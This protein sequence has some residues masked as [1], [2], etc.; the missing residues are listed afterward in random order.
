MSAPMRERALEALDR[1]ALI[2]LQLDRGRA[3]LARVLRHPAWAK[4][5]GGVRANSSRRSHAELDSAPELDIGN[6]AELGEQY[7]ELQRRFPHITVLGAAAAPTT[8]TST[9]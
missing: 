2:A 3:S 1:E 8:A 5:L 6:P 7:G 9:A 4:R